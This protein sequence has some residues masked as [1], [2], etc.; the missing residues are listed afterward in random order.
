MGNKISKVRI[1]PLSVIILLCITVFFSDLGLAK[2]R[3]KR[4]RRSQ[5]AVVKNNGSA[6]YLDRS[7]DAPIIAYMEAG[8][9]V[10]ISRKKYKGL[11]GFGI[12]F[13]IKVKKGKVGYIADTDIV[14][15]FK[16]KI[17]QKKISENP[18]FKDLTNS[19]KKKRKKPRDPI[20]FSRYVGLTFSS[21]NFTETIASKDVSDS[22]TVFGL[23]LSGPGTI[24][25]DLPLDTDISV[26]MAPPSYYEIL[27]DN[28]VA[29]GLV[30]IA[31]TSLMF[32]LAEWADTLINYSLGLSTV[33]TSVQFLGG[34]RN[35]DSQEFR[36]GA[37]AGVAA[38]FRFARDY[39]FKLE[40][41]YFYEKTQYMGYG[42]ALQMNY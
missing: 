25:E 41:K 38:N 15:R 12:F 37:L 24:M 42:A 34:G 18:L 2:K 4:R 29:T 9:K 13:K 31:H 40:A 36:I 19:K 10:K 7:F 30:L 22:L 23:R 5:P 17:G 14:P 28:S 39:L 35:F 1:A 21:V 20:Y 3:R 11:G 26:S 33:Y 8:K 32:P 27:S 6:V 16:K